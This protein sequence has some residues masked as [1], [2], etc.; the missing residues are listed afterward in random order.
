MRTRGSNWEE[1]LPKNKMDTLHT[2]LPRK[3]SFINSW[4]K[5]VFSFAPLPEHDP[6]KAL[7]RPCGSSRCKTHWCTSLTHPA[8]L[9]SATYRAGTFWAHFG[10][11]CM[12]IL[13]YQMP[14]TLYMRKCMSGEHISGVLLYL[15][16]PWLWNV[17]CCWQ[18]YILLKHGCVFCTG[19]ANS[20]GGQ[21]SIVLMR[22]LTNSN[23][24]LVMWTPGTLVEA[25]D[26]FVM[27]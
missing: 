18:K 9:Q 12:S 1:E 4:L 19:G 6:F 27:P 24:S 21:T 20:Q 8:Q 15:C 22:C 23:A 11:R 10:K 25:R 17:N 7:G 5:E 13:C 3:S 26:C 16:A 14:Q 2:A